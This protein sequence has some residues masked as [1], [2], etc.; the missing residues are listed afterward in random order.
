MPAPGTFLF[1]TCAPDL[2]AWCKAEVARL[3]PALRLAFSRPGLLTWKGDTLPGEDEPLWLGPFARV[4]GHSLGRA[5]SAVEAAAL[6]AARGRSGRN[7]LHVF[8]R[9]PARGESDSTR[10]A[11]DGGPAPQAETI[12]IN[13]RAD[14]DL[15]ERLG[16]RLQPRSEVRPGDRVFDV[17]LPPPGE[18]EAAWLVGVHRHGDRASPHP[19]GPR[20]VLVPEDAPSRAFAK[21][22]EAIDWARVP[23]RTGQRALEIGAAPGGACLALLRRGVSVVA[24][25]PAALDARLTPYFTPEKSSAP[26]LHHLRIAAGDLTAAMLPGPVDWL[27][28][29]MNLAAT[30]ALGYVERI[31]SLLRRSGGARGGGPRGVIVTLKLNDEHMVRGLPRLLDRVGHLG[32]GVA[33][34]AHLPS[35]RKEVVAVAFKG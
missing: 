6:I 20:A 24:L 19:G 35:H 21:I 4:A 29:D 18:P 27:L 34:A 32:F 5:T 30:V 14:Q 22:E 31:V 11:D 33:R 15:R 7:H 16:D 12:A 10:A 25:D 28:C 26:T 8:A 3:H 13:E 23:V 1:A 17:I 9:L 2:T